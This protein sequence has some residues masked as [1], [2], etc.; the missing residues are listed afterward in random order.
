MAS[1][2]ILLVTSQKVIKTEPSVLT[3]PD[4]QIMN[5]IYATHVHNDE[6]FDVDSLFV[7]V[8]NILK[9]ATAVVDN[10]VLVYIYTCYRKKDFFYFNSSP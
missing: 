10:V 4:D 6:K 7:V 1:N 3:M 2:K 5:H 9:R 8:E